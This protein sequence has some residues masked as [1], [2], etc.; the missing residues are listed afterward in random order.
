MTRSDPDQLMLPL[1]LPSIAVVTPTA[2]MVAGTSRL[3]QCG[4]CGLAAA[5]PDTSLHRH[6]DPLDRC[7][8][9]GGLT[10]WNQ[11]GADLG[12]FH[13]TVDAARWS[14]EHVTGPLVAERD[15]AR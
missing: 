1:A 12:P 9:C 10:W 6:D 14:W 7:P 3:V 4:T 5:V 15:A 2:S 8:R 11:A 13:R